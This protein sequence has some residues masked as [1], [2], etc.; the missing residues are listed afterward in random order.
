MKS[1]RIQF[2]ECVENGDA[3]KERIR[4]WKGELIL[5]ACKRYGDQCRSGKCLE[6]RRK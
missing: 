5:T 1:F 6:E 3:F 2:R 4:S